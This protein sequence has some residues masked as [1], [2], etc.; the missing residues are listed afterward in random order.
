M[1]RLSV[2]GNGLQ[3]AHSKMG[4]RRDNRQYSRNHCL[5]DFIVD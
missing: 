2:S 1:N 3:I 4:Q 5:L